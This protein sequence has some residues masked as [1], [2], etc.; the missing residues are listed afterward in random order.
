M[1]EVPLYMTTLRAVWDRMFEQP[2]YGRRRAKATKPKPE[3]RNPKGRGA[4]YGGTS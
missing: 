1:S 2:L 4:L 3:T